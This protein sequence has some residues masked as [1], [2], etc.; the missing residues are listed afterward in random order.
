M[1]GVKKNSRS[2]QTTF[3]S[4]SRYFEISVFEIKTVHCTAMEPKM[5]VL[6]L[7]PETR[8]TANDGWM[9][10]QRFTSFSIVFQSYQDDGRMIMKGC[11]LW[12]PV[13]GIEDF[14]LSGASTR[15]LDQKASA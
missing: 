5:R 10:D 9:D 12:N 13:Y 11:V 6:Q 8:N 15:S 4:V 7:Q 3:F 1:T 14:A 2:V